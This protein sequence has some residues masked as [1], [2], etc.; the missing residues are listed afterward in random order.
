M[1]CSSGAMPTCK[2][3]ALENCLGHKLRANPDNSRHRQYRIYD[4]AGTLV[5]KTSLSHSWRASTDIRP[6]MFSTIRKE[7][8]LPENDDLIDLIACPLSRDDYLQKA[9]ENSA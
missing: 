8:N 6:P 4:D 9:R 2:V 3:G 1:S 7:P 5:A